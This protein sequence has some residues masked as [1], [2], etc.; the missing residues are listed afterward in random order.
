MN[1]RCMFSGK[2]ILSSILVLGLFVPVVTM[3]AYGSEPSKKEVI[4][5]KFADQFPVTHYISRNGGQFWMKRVTELTNGRVQFRHFPGEQMGK[6]SDMLDIL[7][8]GVADAGYI[9][10]TYFAGRMPLITGAASYTGCWN[11][12]VEGNPAVMEIATTSPVLENDFLKNG[13]RPILPFANAPY[14]LWL[15]NKEVKKPGDMKGLKI[16]SGGGELDKV[17]ASYGAIP[18]QIPAPE[19]YEA[20]SRGT[21]DGI[22]LSGASGHAYRVEEVCKYGVW[23]INIS[24]GTLGFVINEKVYQR[25]PDDVKKAMAQASKEASENLGRET[26][27]EDL[28]WKQ[29]FIKKGMK[30][31]D[32]TPAEQKVWAA[33]QDPVKEAWFKAMAAKGLDGRGV[34]ERLYKLSEKNR[35]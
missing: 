17:I 6:S 31:T 25:M 27:K 26:V 9:A 12:S 34:L 10:F 21:V 35:K 16:R 20:L 19:I 2:K 3:S 30:M 23:G 32:L 29:E 4:T 7:G 13:I 5:L 14:Q 1:I 24:G 15:T 11:D 33:Y 22:T 8:H 28:K 18:V